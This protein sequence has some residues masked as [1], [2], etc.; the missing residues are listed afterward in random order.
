MEETSI[1]A[2]TLATN[3]K[4]KLLV[5]KS[6]GVEAITIGNDEGDGLYDININLE[7]CSVCIREEDS[8]RRLWLRVV[9]SNTEEFQRLFQ[10]NE[11]NQEKTS[12]AKSSD[13]KAA[14]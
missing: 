13:Q 10:S 4:P 2:S 7:I 14:Q 9:P 11:S 8:C 6:N 12:H 1:P 5:I 3:A